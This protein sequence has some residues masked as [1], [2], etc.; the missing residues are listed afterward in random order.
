MDVNILTALLR[1]ILTV[2]T[3]LNTGEADDIH[4]QSLVKNLFK[5]QV[6]NV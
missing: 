4:R 5:L 6:N 1:T 3:V 2:T